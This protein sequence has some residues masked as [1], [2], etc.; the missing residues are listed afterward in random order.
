M[1]TKIR[2]LI[3][4]AILAL[5]I[6]PA[7]QTVLADDPNYEFYIKLHGDTFQGGD[8]SNH[9]LYVTDSDPTLEIVCGD[10]ID[11]I[12]IQ[13]EAF[14]GFG[15]GYK[16]GSAQNLDDGDVLHLKDLMGG[17]LQ[18]GDYRIKYKAYTVTGG[19]L[20]QVGWASLVEFDNGD[21][22]DTAFDDGYHLGVDLD[23]PSVKSF[24]ATHKSMTEIEISAWIWEAP[25]GIDRVKLYVN[26]EEYDVIRYNDKPEEAKLSWTISGLD[27]LTYNDAEIEISDWAGHTTTDDPFDS[28]SRPVMKPWIRMVQLL[29]NRFPLL[30]QLF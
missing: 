25:S 16:A 12:V 13:V 8:N 20:P 6:L 18:S 11:F 19:T 5:F 10:Y 1:K 14:I 17:T 2:A 9:Q 15:D 4:L 27:A 28:L 3:C 7:A 30:A 23:G 26:G 22:W 29:F 24:K 21:R